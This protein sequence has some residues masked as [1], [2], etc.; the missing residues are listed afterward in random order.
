MMLEVLV[1]RHTTFYRN[2]KNIACHEA[3]ALVGDLI[4]I[5]HE[6]HDLKYE[7]KKLKSLT[8]V[9]SRSESIVEERGMSS[10]S[11]NHLDDTCEQAESAIRRSSEASK[12][13]DAVR[14]KLGSVHKLIVTCVIWLVFYSWD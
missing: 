4:S 1:L 2:F 5:V 13:I 7:F 10:I 14:L 11:P 9:E 8:S 3:I 6:V 12:D